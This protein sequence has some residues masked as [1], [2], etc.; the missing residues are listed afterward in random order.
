[1]SKCSNFIQI[2]ERID[3]HPDPGAYKEK[4]EARG[5]MWQ[6]A[7]EQ[8]APWCY[9]PPEYG[10]VMVGDPIVTQDGYLVHLVRTSESSMFGEEAANLWFTLEIQKPYRMRIKI[11]DDKP[12]FSYYLFKYIKMKNFSRF[13]VPI[14]IPSDGT[15]PDDDQ[16]DFLIN[17]YNSPVFGFKVT[18]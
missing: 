16:I 5:C 3:C 18:R 2:N 12:R 8:G 10:Y 6:E 11:T 14:T 7:E 9:Y 15:R 4:C 13:E 17:F 1:M